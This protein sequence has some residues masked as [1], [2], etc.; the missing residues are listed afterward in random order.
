MPQL[1]VAEKSVTP[2][3]PTTTT[4]PTKCIPVS[5]KPVSYDYLHKEVSHVRCVLIVVDKIDISLEPGAHFP[6]KQNIKAP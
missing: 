2:R 6:W 1:V 4:T 5:E 3:Q